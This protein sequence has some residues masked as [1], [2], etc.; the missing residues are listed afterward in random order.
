M[1]QLWNQSF[2]H[3]R[4][5]I[6]RDDARVAQI[7]LE[8]VLMKDA[9]KL[10]DARFPDVLAGIVTVHCTSPVL[11]I[12]SKT[13]FQQRHI[14]EQEVGGDNRV[15]ECRFAKKRNQSESPAGNSVLGYRS[16]KWSSTGQSAWHPVF[17][18]RFCFLARLHPK[19][20]PSRLPSW[21]TSEVYQH[22]ASLLPNRMGCEPVWSGV[23]YDLRG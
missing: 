19:Q 15:T 4:Q 3:L 11:T 16:V 17:D 22:G 5:Q 18:F 1:F 9:H 23:R 6:E 12:E 20:E 10:F 8:D 7:H 2:I 21:Q 14:D 13:A